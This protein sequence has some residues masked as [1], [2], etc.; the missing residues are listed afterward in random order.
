MCSVSF[1][2]SIF[3]FILFYFIIITVFFFGGGLGLKAL[4]ARLGLGLG[5][6]VSK[7]LA[8]LSNCRGKQRLQVA[9]L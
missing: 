9:G 1:F 7:P 3:Y 2:F 4:F 5:L 8:V 6:R